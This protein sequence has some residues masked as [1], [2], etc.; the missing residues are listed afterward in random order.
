MPAPKPRSRVRQTARDMV[1]SLAVVGVFV[2][3]LV[4]VNYREK[5]DPVRVVDPAPAVAQARAQAAFVP[6]VPVGLPAA[7]RPTSARYE[8]AA[9][10]AVPNAALWHLGYLTPTD[11]YAAVDQVEG[12]PTVAVRA[13]VEGARPSRGGHRDLRRL[14][15]LAD[16]RRTTDGV[17]PSGQRQHRGR[18]RHRRRPRAR[19]LRRRAPSAARRL[20][21]PCVRATA[22]Y[23]AP[24][25]GRTAAADS[26][27][28]APSS[29]R[30][31][32]VA[33]SSPRSHSARDS[34]R[35]A[36]TGLE[37]PD[38]LDELVAGLPRRTTWSPGPRR[39]SRWSETF[40]RVGRGVGSLTGPP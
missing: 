25:V 23:C 9:I 32:I 2:A 19:D 17:R 1:W 29:Q 24:S 8:R 14:A 40:G 7:W 10:S 5:P 4:A 34:S 27:A 3:F 38:D 18:V 30:W 35:V 39:R 37:A 12:D 20:T 22:R 13:L 26:L 16:R 6:V 28:R 33:S 36:P 15:A 31:Q 11:A 21:L